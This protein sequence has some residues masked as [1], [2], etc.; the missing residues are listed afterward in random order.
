M[1]HQTMY[2]KADYKTNT[3]SHAADSQPKMLQIIIDEKQTTTA[4][5][6]SNSFVNLIYLREVL[7]HIEHYWEDFIVNKEGFSTRMFY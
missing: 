4:H 6:I 5:S 2:L 3:V 7:K 1:S